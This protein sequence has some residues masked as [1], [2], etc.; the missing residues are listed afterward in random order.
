MK[1]YKKFKESHFIK[2][3]ENTNE[4]QFVSKYEEWHMLRLA[5]IRHATRGSFPPMESWNYCGKKQGTAVISLEPEFKSAKQ[6][7][8]NDNDLANVS[9][10]SYIKYLRSTPGQVIAY[11]KPVEE[12][13]VVVDSKNAWRYYELHSIL[14]FIANKAVDFTANRLPSDTFRYRDKY[15]VYHDY[16]RRFDERPRGD[17][18]FMLRTA[19]SVNFLD[20]QDIV[21]GIYDY[22]DDKLILWDRSKKCELLTWRFDDECY[23]GNIKVNHKFDLGLKFIKSILPDYFE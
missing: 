21:F 10:K 22:N 17:V 23:K 7:S 19:D 12:F 18:L 11:Y 3:G 1:A 2:K 9:A 8:N 15:G 20:C 5:A 14:N 13:T 16:D 4:C 6:L